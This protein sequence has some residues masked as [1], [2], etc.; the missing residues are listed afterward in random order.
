MLKINNRAVD[1]RMFRLTTGEECIARIESEDDT[2]FTVT[3]PRILGIKESA[4]G[5]HI[6]PH[7]LMVT[8]QGLFVDIKA[9]VEMKIYKSAIMVEHMNVSD[10]LYDNFVKDTSAISLV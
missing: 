10:D 1:V 8:D 3:H 2:T 9:S 6:A 4:E 7:P 5:M